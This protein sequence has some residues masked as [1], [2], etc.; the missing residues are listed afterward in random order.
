[1]KDEFA[2]LETKLDKIDDRLGSID[3]TLAA[4]HVSLTEH[5][6]RTQLLEEQV[7]PLQKRSDMALGVYKFI[8]LL[9]IIAAIAEGAVVALEY[10]GKRH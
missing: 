6:R 1:M 5:I 7:A 10:L 9:S 3:S 2:K 4:Q 8:G